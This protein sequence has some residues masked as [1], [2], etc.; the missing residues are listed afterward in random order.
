MEFSFEKTACYLIS[1]ESRVDRREDFI[2]NIKANQFSENQFNW[3]VAIRDNN[4]GG[5]G[6]AKSHLLALS[7][8]VSKTESQYCC[9]LEDDFRFRCTKEDVEKVINTVDKNY[10]W[11]VFLLAGTQVVS[12]PTLLETSD[13]KIEKLFEGCT[14]SG[15]IL[16]REYAKHLIINMLEC[17]EGM[18]RYKYLEPRSL[19]YHSFALD[20]VWKPI[21]RKNNWYCTLPMLGFQ[22][23]GF[24]DIEKK[25]VNY[26]EYSQ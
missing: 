20:Q 8:F 22:V 11:D 18:E 10:N 26:M 16:K 6:C 9:I 25:E 24:S 21:Q 23:E 4:F 3:L 1:L 7:E 2:K 17:I 15:Y 12:I 14:S 5:L 13:H 19:I